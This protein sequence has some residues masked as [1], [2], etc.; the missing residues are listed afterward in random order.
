MSIKA[1]LLAGAVVFAAS[2]GSA[3][4]ADQGVKLTGS[5]P[6]PSFNAL[7][8]VTVEPMTADAMAR[9]VGGY[10]GNTKFVFDPLLGK[11]K[12]WHLG[13]MKNVCSHD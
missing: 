13:L 8:G 3:S 7:T 6:P 2:V 12:G 4:A 11:G 5:T 9:V 1:T 10:V